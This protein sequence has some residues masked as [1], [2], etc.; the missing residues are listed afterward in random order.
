M[1]ITS[2]AV[3]PNFTAKLKNN[4]VTTNLVKK[5]DKNQLK[6]FKT[7]LAELDKTHPDDVLELKR[8]GRFESKRGSGATYSIVNLK[9]NKKS[10]LVTPVNN[11]GPA[12]FINTIKEIATV[13][14]KKH[15]AVLGD[16]E[17]E[18]AQNE[19][20]DMMV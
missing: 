13:G 3:A 2:N 4:D 10:T 7:A 8:T 20:F 5:M 17:K 6:E 14:S 11:F 19:I 1:N 12:S 16:A 15:N 18:Q 9:S